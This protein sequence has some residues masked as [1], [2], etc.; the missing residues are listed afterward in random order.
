MLPGASVGEGARLRR[1]VVGEQVEVSA[2]SVWSEVLLTRWRA[3][4]TTPPGS[5]RDG[6]LVVTP[7]VR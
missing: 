2:G 6:A 7:F 1:V 4:G 5:R 3:D